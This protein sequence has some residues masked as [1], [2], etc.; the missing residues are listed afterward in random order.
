VSI[1]ANDAVA[2]RAMGRKAKL[3]MSILL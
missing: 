3:F 1:V 2:N